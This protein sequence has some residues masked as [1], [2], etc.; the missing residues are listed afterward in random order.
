VE[1]FLLQDLVAED[2]STL[3]FFTPLEGFT[4][5]PVPASV[6]A[7][8]TYRQ[9]AIEFIEARNFRILRSL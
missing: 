7:Y 1:F 8:R 2:C 9:L 6:E 5:S 4:A 3:K